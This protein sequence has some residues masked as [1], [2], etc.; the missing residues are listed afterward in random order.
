M[1]LPASVLSAPTPAVRPAHRWKVLAVGVAAN[2]A[3]S[4]AAAGLPATAVFLR[5]DYQLDNDALGLALGVLGLGVALF[6]LPW[7]L[8]ADRWGD[9]PV[10]L[11]GLG[12]TAAALA[13]MSLFAAPAH[14]VAP[15]LWLLALGLLLVGVMGGSVN[16]ASGRAVMAWFDEG[17]RGLAMSIRQTAVPLGGGLGAL[18]LPW[19]ASRAGFGAVFGLLAG[20]CAGAA[21]L[22]LGWLREPDRAH[23]ATATGSTAA[24]H[25]GGNTPT[26]SPPSRGAT[27][28]PIAAASSPLRDARVWRAAAAIGLLCCPQFAVLTF[29]TVFLHDFSGAG[30]ATLT[31]VMVAV[32]LGAMVARIASGRWT[33]RHGNRRAYLRGCVWL[34]CVLFVALAAAAWLQCAVPG[35]RAALLAVPVLLAAAGICASAW[36]GVAYTEL[37]TL[38]GAARAGTALGLANTCVYLGLFLTPLAL[39]RLVA[40][41]SWPLAWL[42]AGGAML[43]ILPLLPRPAR[44]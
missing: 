9:R 11:G 16:G 5:A 1:S 42:A 30:I 10:L 12:A 4:A 43:A 24:S 15:A 19:L 27:H 28:T 26:T 8:L 33:D 20:L 21:L 25:A 37:A 40:A 3:F 18:V 23:P 29:A 34:G 31:A 13:W 44:P 6:E 32:Q 38:A 22:T 17:E 2:A 36:H 14:G 39:P 35:N 41:A 7:G